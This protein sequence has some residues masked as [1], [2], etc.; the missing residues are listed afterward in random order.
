MILVVTGNIIVTKKIFTIDDIE[1]PNNAEASVTA[2][3]NANN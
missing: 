3:N 2:T 1:A